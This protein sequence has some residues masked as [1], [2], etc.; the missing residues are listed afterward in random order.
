MV[1]DR[2]TLMHALHRTVAVVCAALVFALGLFSASPALH[3]QLHETG[4]AWHHDPCA[5]VQFANGASV[6]VAVTV[7]A[8]AI[9][10]PRIDPPARSNEI[11][12]DSPRYL[13]QPERGP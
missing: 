13:L 5:I 2:Q 3:K 7:S 8:P 6:P 10:A 4:D 12:L 11:C 9:A 1:A